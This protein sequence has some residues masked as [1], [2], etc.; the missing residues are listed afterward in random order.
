M[1]QKLDYSPPVPW[2][3]R[4][5]YRRV[6]ALVGVMVFLVAAWREGP[7][8]WFRFKLFYYERQCLRYAG[9]KD[10]IVGEPATGTVKWSDVEYALGANFGGPPATA[11]TQSVGSSGQ[12]LF[13]GGSLP[14]KG[15]ACL[16][17]LHSLLPSPGFAD[18]DARGFLHERKNRQGVRK[19]VMVRP[20]VDPGEIDYRITDVETLREK[21]IPNELWSM[22]CYGSSESPCGAILRIYAGQAD[23]EDETH[24]TFRYELR[25]QSGTIDAYL[26]DGDEIEFRVRDGPAVTPPEP[27]ALPSDPMKP[28]RPPTGMDLI[29]D[30]P[31]VGK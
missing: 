6:F 24:F 10:E 19:L 16:L 4:R 30:R 27:M 3:R 18:V 23:P 21:P 12:G 15:P 5:R 26:R 8:V 25:G 9:A 22:S 31:S 14:P 11:T 20:P 1:P 17:K 2:H 28:F 7:E 29:D 13:G